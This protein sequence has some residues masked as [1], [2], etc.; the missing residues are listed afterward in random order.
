MNKKINYIILMIIGIFCSGNISTQ[1]ET[2]YEKLRKYKWRYTEEQEGFVEFE[3]DSI[4]FSGANCRGNKYDYRSS[5]Y[6]VFDSS[7]EAKALMKDAD[8]FDFDKVGKNV[9]GE[10]IAVRKQVGIVSEWSKKYE[11]HVSVSVYKIHE[12]TD[13]IFKYSSVDEYLN[14]QLMNGIGYDTYTCKPD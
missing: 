14:P 6:Y 4:I 3:K 8:L 11:V 12:L 2:T 1:E 7:D 10:Y 5:I 13:K 9:C